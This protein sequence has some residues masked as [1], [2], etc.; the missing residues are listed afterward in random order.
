[1]ST[2]STRAANSRPNSSIG[3]H[4]DVQETN[5]AVVVRVRPRNQKEIRENSPVVITTNGSR[6]KELIV[7]STLGDSTT[8]TYSFDRVFGPEADQ[9]MVF[10]DVL[11]PML[12]EVLMGYNCTI[13]AYG[14]TGT[15]KTYTME[16]DLTTV[17][18]EH[19]GIIPRTLHQLFT[20]LEAGDNAEYSVRVSFTEL[21][22]E[23]LK[24]LLS[25]DED[26]RKL[27]IFDD[28][29]K[30]GSI[31]IQNLEETPVKCADDVIAVLQKGSNRKQI[32]ATKM[33]EVSSRSHSIFC[34][35]VNT[36]ETTPEGEELLRVG[37][38]NLVDLAGSENIGRSGAENRRAKEAGMINQSL[39]TLGRVINALLDRNLHIPYR[40]SKLTRILQDSL[41]G[42]TKTCI[43]AAVSPARC[44][45]E[46]TLSTVD[47]AHRAKNIRNKPE[48][49]QKMTKRALLKDYEVEIQRLRTLIEAAHKKDGVFMP[50]E[51]YDSMMADTSGSKEEAEALSKAIKAAEE[52]YLQL[53][54]Q[55]N[56]NMELLCKT[57]EERDDFMA[58]SASKAQ[59]LEE[60]FQRLKDLENSLNEQKLLTG[61]HAASERKLDRLAAGLVVTLKS[62]ISDVEGLHDKIGRKTARETENRRIFGEF[63]SG[64]LDQMQTI[65]SQ[66]GNL[67]S[68]STNFCREMEGTI[69]R[70]SETLLKDLTCEIENIG[71]HLVDA[72]Q[73][74]QN[75]LTQSNTHDQDIGQQ[76]E[77]VSTIVREL[78]ASLSESQKRYQETNTSLF[79]S[80]KDLV[81]QHQKQMQEWSLALK[82]SVSNVNKSV[83][84][85]IEDERSTAEAVHVENDRQLRREI[86]KLREQNLLLQQ[87]LATNK[88]KSDAGAEA[89]LAGIASLVANYRSQCDDGFTAIGQL[90]SDVT[91][92]HAAQLSSLVD[93]NAAASAEARSSREQFSARFTR[94]TDK[95][96]EEIQTEVQGLEVTVQGFVEQCGIIENAVQESIGS[97]GTAITTG[98]DQIVQGH[99]TG[100]QLLTQRSEKTREMVMDLQ[101]STSDSF[102]AVQKGLSTVRKTAKNEHQSWTQMLTRQ[103]GVIND[104]RGNLGSHIK[105]ARDEIECNKL[106]EDQP[107]G[108]TPQKKA[109]RYAT[110]WQITRNHDE[111]LR[112]YRQNGRMVSPTFTARSFED[113]LVDA[114]IDENEE[115]FLPSAAED[116]RATDPFSDGKRGDGPPIGVG[117]PRGA[118]KLPM[119]MKLRQ[120]SRKASESPVP[121][122]GL[123]SG[124]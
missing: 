110:S 118:S 65:D 98:L 76:L 120:N 67:T 94:D 121:F 43:I 89:L 59:Q 107:T 52:K 27:R 123:E 88:Q 103:S 50:K 60:T 87:Q 95:L 31:V 68:A 3:S 11:A 109:F 53:N 13:F 4:R 29:A 41:G 62:S 46:E 104:H 21:Y 85:F 36:K 42:T 2:M 39:L 44:N 74:S 84:A 30:K 32:A 112:E 1:M 122:R 45:I 92:T 20:T 19:A 47:Y 9:E 7:K 99:A 108:Q 35:T 6:G 70:G 115:N 49:N 28:Y 73:R 48:V 69:S 33:N 82:E 114:P 100:K 81:L 10:N 24:D 56:K 113:A 78:R 93:H 91:E 23:E 15:G 5:I 86:E 61:A 71:G 102:D 22:N 51:M 63:Q 83:M 105:R 38:L 18:G 54:T 17:K 25:P 57:K 97:T 101:S 58:E 116:D 64:L 37:K 96:T 117:T 72:A 12:K 77:H 80:H 55:H 14:Q 16:G 75:F 26:S 124:Q 66:I 8:K 79:G 106:V 34:I 90:S 119:M 111:I 40:E